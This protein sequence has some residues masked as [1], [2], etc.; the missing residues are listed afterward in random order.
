MKTK[1]HILD[2]AEQLDKKL[3]EWLGLCWH[4]FDRA[5][6]E[7]GGVISYCSKCGA[8]NYLYG[9]EDRSYWPINRNRQFTQSLDL[10]FVGLMSYLDGWQIEGV[11]D[12]AQARV[13]Y[14]GKTVKAISRTPA[15]ALCGAMVAIIEKRRRK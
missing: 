15:M 10:C 7:W 1:E 5:G 14:G 3:T 13:Y 8:A 6:D 9:G 2:E 12:L 4:E 11:G